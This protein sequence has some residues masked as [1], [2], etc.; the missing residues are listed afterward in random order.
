MITEFTR[1]NIKEIRAEV[2]SALHDIGQKHGIAFK[3]NGISY[4]SDNFRST[5]NA[6][7]TE[8]SGDTVYSV[9][10][11]N[12]CWKYGFQKEDLGKEFRSGDNRFKIVGLKTRNRKYPVIAE[13]VQTGKLHKF[14]ALAVKE[15]LISPC[16]RPIKF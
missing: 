9:E 12:K 2:D 4:G 3:I 1:T 5:I 14:T 10:F 7:I 16:E 11:K 6:V 13:N 15:N 8:H